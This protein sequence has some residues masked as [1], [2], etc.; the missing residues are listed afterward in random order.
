MTATKVVRA[1]LGGRHPRTGECIHVAFED[2]GVPYGIG[3]RP[4]LE[5]RSFRGREVQTARVSLAI[6]GSRMCEPGL[7]GC[8]PGLA[9]VPQL[10]GSDLVFSRT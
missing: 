10:E 8:S 7:G 3:R 1:A 6:T 4:G 5:G 9:Q 2:A